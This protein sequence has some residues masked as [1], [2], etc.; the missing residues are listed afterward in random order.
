MI[1]IPQAPRIRALAQTLFILLNRPSLALRIHAASQILYIIATFHYLGQRRPVALYL[2]L[3]GMTIILERL[4]RKFR[5]VP[6]YIL[7]SSLGVCNSVYLNMEGYGTLYWGFHLTVAVALASKYFLRV[8]R[9]PIFNPSAVGI[10]VCMLL[11]PKYVTADAELWRSNYNFIV[12]AILGFTVSS[13]AGTLPVSLSYLL[14]ISLS[15][16]LLTFLVAVLSTWVP[17]LRDSGATVASLAVW[18][19]ASMSVGFLIFAFHVISDPVTAPAG[20]RGKI[21]YGLCIGALEVA[22][23]ALYIPNGYIISYVLC[24][25]CF[26]I[27][28]NRKGLGIASRFNLTPVEALRSSA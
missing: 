24:N 1:R 11:V 19:L 15:G 22:L 21:V 14:G 7:L 4:L 20:R 2:S 8:G 28:E 16:V 10:F 12:V 13:L 18:P 25:L 5:A 23:R 6:G 27:Y 26:S 9:G 3:I 17:A